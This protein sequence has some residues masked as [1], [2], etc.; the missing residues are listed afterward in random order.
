[1]SALEEKLQELRLEYMR[2]CREDYSIHRGLLLQTIAARC[3]LY[4]KFLE[5]KKK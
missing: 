5:E 3:K 4:R 1:M 2:V